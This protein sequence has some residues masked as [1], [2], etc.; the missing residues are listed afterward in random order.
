MKLEFHPFA[1]QNTL[2]RRRIVTGIVAGLGAL[3]ARSALPQ[4]QQPA[5]QEKPSSAATAAQTTLHYEIDYAAAPQR[6]Y[7]ALLESKQFAAFTGLPA[8][9]DA[10]P[11]GA[12]ALFGKLIDGRNVELVENQRIVQAWRPASWHPG[13]YSIAHFELRARG[14]GSR[15]VFDHT[16]FPAGLANSLDEGWHGHYWEPLKK[17][18]A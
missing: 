17:Y 8:E 1:Q 4:S 9:I 7:A 13:I 15:L 2:S 5:M 10:K 16:G 11:G 6:I 18:L 3:A 14:A 12:F